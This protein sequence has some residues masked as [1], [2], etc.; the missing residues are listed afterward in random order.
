MVDHIKR[1]HE[2]T[3]KT[4]IIVCDQCDVVKGNMKSLTR[5]KRMVHQPSKLV[6]SKTKTKHQCLKC[7]YKAGTTGQLSEH[8]GKHLKAR[9]SCDICDEKFNRRSLVIGHIKE[10]HKETGLNSFDDDVHSMITCFCPECKFLGPSRDYDLH[11]QKFHDLPKRKVWKVRKDSSKKQLFFCG[12][13]DQQ[14]SALFPLQTHL[15][16]SHLEIFYTCDVCEIR[17]DRNLEIKEHMTKFHGDTKHKSTTCC[18]VCKE[19]I[20]DD[21]N[22]KHVMK[23]HSE[24]IKSVFVEKEEF[25][26]SKRQKNL[27][28]DVKI[29]SSQCQYCNSHLAPKETVSHQLFFHLKSSFACPPCGFTTVSKPTMINH[30]K[31]LHGESNI[32]SS[33]S[34]LLLCG[35]C[36]FKAKETELAKHIED[37]EDI[38][39][40]KMFSLYTC[41]VCD[42]KHVSRKSLQSHCAKEK[43]EAQPMNCEICNYKTDRYWN[44][45]THVKLMHRDF[46]YS[47]E[48]C[49]FK[50]AHTA[51]LKRHIESIHDQSKLHKCIKCLKRFK[52]NEFLQVHIK[53]HH[54]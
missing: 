9:F 45:V 5:H 23:A 43:H 48:Q 53:S 40:Y 28:K 2:E 26:K 39:L 51:S 46:K 4:N 35:H 8:I 16:K 19:T 30:I 47:C 3:L 49:S 17:I 24:F 34:A 10:E 18:T 36:E 15:A 6:G 32:A 37:H 54:S 11:L 22:F 7:P 29:E 1:E 14:Y 44:L 25:K 20:R 41:E 50:T 21:L 33:K 12:K 31:T 42:F 38:L 13:C 52:R 27:R